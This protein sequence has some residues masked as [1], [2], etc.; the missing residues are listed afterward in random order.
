MDSTRSSS[1]VVTFSGLSFRASSSSSSSSSSAL[2][3]NR[4]FLTTAG[5]LVFSKKEAAGKKT[6]ASK[7]D[8]EKQENDT[9]HDDTENGDNK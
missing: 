1:F 3:F 2:R 4:S 5:L 9:E 7:K 8:R 6:R